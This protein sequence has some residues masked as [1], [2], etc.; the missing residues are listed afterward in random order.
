MR[1]HERCRKTVILL[2]DI[3]EKFSRMELTTTLR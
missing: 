3:D 2:I 1:T